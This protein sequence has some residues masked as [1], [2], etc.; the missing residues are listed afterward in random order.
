MF[1]IMPM[2]PT[3]SC[4]KE[5][6]I[7]F[8]VHI[9]KHIFPNVMLLH[10]VESNAGGF[11]KNFNSI[12]YLYRG[13]CCDTPLYMCTVYP[14]LVHPLHYSLSSPTPLLKMTSTGFNVPYSYMYRKYLNHIHR[15]LLSSF[16]FPLLLLPSPCHNLFTFL[17]FIA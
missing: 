17:S 4:Y 9:S 7:S 2:F 10:D 8:F 16:T 15:P 14:S 3:A 5:N 13:L 6:R 12:Y 11:K 1:L